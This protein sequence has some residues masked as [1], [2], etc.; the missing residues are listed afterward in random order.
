MAMG[1]PGNPQ[2]DARVRTCPALPVRTLGGHRAA[3]L[4]RVAATLRAQP[5]GRSSQ[6]RAESEAEARQGPLGSGPGLRPAECY[7][8][9]GSTTGA[10]D[11]R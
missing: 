6:G 7:E 11:R 8:R 5:G 3:K 2:V 9:V 1:Q 4:D 10:G